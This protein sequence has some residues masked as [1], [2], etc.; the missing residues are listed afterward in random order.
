[1]IQNLDFYQSLVS[2]VLRGRL[3]FDAT[4]FTAMARGL[5]SSLPATNCV[6]IDLSVISTPSASS[7]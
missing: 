3:S 7:G 2:F 4:L 5:L 6:S 1:M